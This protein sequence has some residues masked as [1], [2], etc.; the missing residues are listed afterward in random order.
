MQS[1]TKDE[2][3]IVLE[4]FHQILKNENMK[5]IQDKS[6]FFSTRIQFLGHFIGRNTITQ[7]KPQA[8]AI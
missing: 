1:Q 2:M 7:I 6:L 8:V 4:Q 5:A 3:F